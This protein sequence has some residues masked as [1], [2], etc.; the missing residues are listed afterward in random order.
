MQV[1]RRNLPVVTAVLLALVL[2]S[3]FAT[4]FST[5]ACRA[6]YARLQELESEQWYLQEDYGRLVLEQSTQASH[7]RVESIARGD[8]GMTEP[9][10][11]QFKVVPK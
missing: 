9:D 2:F 4:I 10:L 5:H 7:Y 6:L 3:A 11:A 8:L 1:S